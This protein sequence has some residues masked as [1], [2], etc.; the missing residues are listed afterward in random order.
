[1]ND[2]YDISFESGTSTNEISLFDTPLV[3]DE[4]E[5]DESSL[6]FS[7]ML[8]ELQK[9]L[10]NIDPNLG[11]ALEIVDR[12]ASSLLGGIKVGLDINHMAQAIKIALDDEDPLVV[13][14]ATAEA[15]KKLFIAKYGIITI[16]AGFI[17]P[18]A[19]IAM[20][21]VG[22][23]INEYGDFIFDLAKPM[24]EDLLK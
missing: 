5:F 17:N 13:Q 18:V 23:V 12:K 16:Y 20:A 4:P 14:S 2:I 7:L 24:P 11:I 21:A 15:L 3:F 8:M 9:D 10:G 19:S 6:D 1:M 22:V